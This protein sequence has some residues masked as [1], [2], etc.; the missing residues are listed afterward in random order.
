M[1]SPATSRLN[2]RSCRD[3]AVT[4]RWSPSPSPSSSSGSGELASTVADAADH[5]RSGSARTA[6]RHRGTT[7]HHGW[8]ED[9][10]LFYNGARQPWHT[11][12]YGTRVFARAVQ[13]SGLPKGTTSHDLPHHYTSVLL[14]GGESVVAGRGAAR[15]GERDVGSH[16]VRTPDAGQRRAPSAGAGRGLVS[17][18]CAPRRRCAVLTCGY[19]LVLVVMREA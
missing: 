4:R 14:A 11:N 10:T 5:S 13:R 18:W 2:R 1:A 19:G 16:D 8:L 6:V 7:W 3:A 9:G 12:R 15:P 17:P